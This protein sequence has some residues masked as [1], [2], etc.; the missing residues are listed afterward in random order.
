MRSHTGGFMTMG[1]VGAYVRSR[2]QKLDTKSS[3]EAD[4]VGVDDVLIQV[5]WT[6]SFLKEQGYIIHDNVIYQDN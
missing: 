2:K 5:I 1:K 6:R 3:T 4:L